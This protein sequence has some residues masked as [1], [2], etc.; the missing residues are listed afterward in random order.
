MLA[1][2]SEKTD[3][4]DLLCKRGCNMRVQ[5]FDHVEPIEYAINKRNLYMSDVLMK[6]ERLSSQNS[7][8]STPHPPPP[9]PLPRPKPTFQT[10][11]DSLPNSASLTTLLH[12]EQDIHNKLNKTKAI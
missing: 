1:V 3:L 8:D 5:G 4:V 6:H 2:R 12:Q 9:T 11:T 7:V 10:N